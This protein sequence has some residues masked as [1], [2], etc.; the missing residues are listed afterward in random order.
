MKGLGIFALGAG[1]FVSALSL[2]PVQAQPQIPNFTGNWGHNDFSYRKPFLTEAGEVIN[3]HDNEYLQ[4]WAAEAIMRDRFG[5]QSGR[6][7]VSD[8]STCHPEGVLGELGNPRMQIVQTPTEITILFQNLHSR[9]VY[10]NRPHSKDPKPSW[11]GE[12]VGH[13]E[14]DTL[15]VDTIGV[16]PSPKIVSSFYGAPFTEALHVVERWQFLPEN[17]KPIPPRTRGAYFSF[18]VNPN[19]VVPGKKILRLT[20]TVTDPGAYQKPWTAMIDYYPLKDPLMEFVCAENNR[21]FVQFSP[22]ANKPD[23]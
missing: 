17:E 2:A 4:G 1:I 13:F 11:Y 23:F 7:V 15:V 6:L 3:G 10:L 22:T 18:P 9:T 5:E 20:L 16:A 8:H 21:S 14:G 19:Q 12:S